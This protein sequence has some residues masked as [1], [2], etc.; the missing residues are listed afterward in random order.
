MKLKKTILAVL[1]GSA[2]LAAAPVFADN[3]WHRGW[4]HHEHYAPR[5]IV[6][7]PVYYAPPPRV[8]YYS[9]APVY[10]APAPVYRTPAP[11]VS[12]AVVYPAPVY[13]PPVQPQ[14]SLRFNLPL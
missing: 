14:V 6:Q 7:E 10:Y 12:G 13:S 5:F 1:A 8:V 3:G 2:A 9:P 4:R 11:I